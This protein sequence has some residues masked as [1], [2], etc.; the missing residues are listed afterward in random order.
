[1]HNLE[2]YV[3]KSEIGK[4]NTKRESGDFYC[5]R[6]QTKFFCILLNCTSLLHSASFENFQTW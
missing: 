6:V 3:N 5:F 4:E 2:F 1:M